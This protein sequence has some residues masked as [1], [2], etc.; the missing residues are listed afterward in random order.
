[1]DLPLWLQSALQERLER[2]MSGIE[3]RPELRKLR[4][5]EGLAFETMFAGMDRTNIPGYMDWEDKHYYKR[6]VE[7]EHL[8]IQGL[9]DGVQVAFTLLADPISISDKS[10]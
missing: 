8:Y 6:G 2:V 10:G 5:E 7:N 3:H 4:S 1:M 9:R